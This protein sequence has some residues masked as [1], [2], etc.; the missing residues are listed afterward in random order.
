MLFTD[1]PLRMA[2]LCWPRYGFC[3]NAFAA[4][5]RERAQKPGQ[6]PALSH[7]LIPCL[8]FYQDG[9]PSKPTRQLG[10]IPIWSGRVLP[11]EHSRNRLP[12]FVAAARELGHRMGVVSGRVHWVRAMFWHAYNLNLLKLFD[13]QHALSKAVLFHGSWHP[14]VHSLLLSPPSIQFLPEVWYFKPGLI[15]TTLFAQICTR[16]LLFHFVPA[17]FT[18]QPFYN[19]LDAE[20]IGGLLMISPECTAAIHK[21]RATDPAYDVSILGL[22]SKRAVVSWKTS[23]RLQTAQLNK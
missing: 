21:N 23:A 7:L 8:D 14:G 6:S 3:M 22:H 2:W 15:T 9:Q 19:R 18:L 4:S 1:L 12:D 10:A 17:T 11:D 13:D 5:M 16:H 20:R